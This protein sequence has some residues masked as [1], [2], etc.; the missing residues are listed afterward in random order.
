MTPGLNVRAGLGLLLDAATCAAD[1]GQ[2]PWTFAVE[3][4]ELRQ[5]GIDNV[6]LRWLIVSDFVAHS[7][8]TFASTSDERQFENRGRLNLTEASCFILTP[9]GVRFAQELLIQ[10]NHEATS[11]LAGRM[12]GP[13]R[14]HDE[15]VPHWDP[16]KRQLEF[17]GRV[18]KAFVRAAWN[19]EAILT[20]FEEEGWPQQVDD[21]IPPAGGRNQRARLR[22]CIQSL[23]RQ[24]APPAIEFGCEPNGA[25]ICW[26]PVV[27]LSIVASPA[28]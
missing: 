28:R 20:A 10:P 3:L 11:R 19:Q 5:R 16:G 12:K 24:A 25:A 21:P 4:D 22:A 7:H 9:A 27:Q 17:R 14:R 2:M 6:W 1:A 15:V 23:N 18:I 13:D 8:E 26:R